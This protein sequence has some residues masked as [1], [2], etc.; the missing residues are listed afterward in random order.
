MYYLRLYELIELSTS[1]QYARAYTQL[2]LHSGLGNI[3]PAL[4]NAVNNYYAQ[5]IWK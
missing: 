2:S 5:R 4:L 1:H 3:C